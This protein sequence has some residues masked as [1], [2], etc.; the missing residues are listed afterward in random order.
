[1]SRPE[2][3]PK[4][5]TSKSHEKEKYTKKVNVESPKVIK[6][7]VKA[8]TEKTMKSKKPTEKKVKNIMDAKKAREEEEGGVETDEPGEE[9]PQPVKQEKK[10]PDKK[11]DKKKDKAKNDKKK[12]KS[13]PV[14]PS[15]D[16]QC[17]DDQD[18]W[19]DINACAK[20][21]FEA[22]AKYDFKEWNLVARTWKKI[23]A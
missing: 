10:K 2:D 4:S 17:T 13:I 14:T 11:A 12:S 21:F 20:K 1:M 3:K 23:C 6:E 16:N 9:I 8:K 7:K 5:F 15:S 18:K 19:K 22:T